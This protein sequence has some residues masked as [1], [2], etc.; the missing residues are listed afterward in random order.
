MIC[1]K[2]FKRLVASIG[3]DGWTPNELHHSG[4]SLM[5]DAGMPI[6]QVADHPDAPESRDRHDR[7][8]ASLKFFVGLIRR[9][10]ANELVDQIANLHVR[11]A[12]SREKAPWNSPPMR[13]PQDRA[14]LA[15]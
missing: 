13:W 12:P 11:T 9:D 10:D 7:I 15:A 14:V 6:E 8:E 4:A 3:L 1:R 5:S 2:E